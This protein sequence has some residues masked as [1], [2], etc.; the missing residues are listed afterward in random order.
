MYQECNF[1]NLVLKNFKF[2]KLN[3]F[4]S[5]KNFM[6][7]DLNFIF[8]KDLKIILCLFKKKN[9]KIKS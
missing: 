2:L 9:L 7:F 8:Y 1:M 3:L 4:Y 5:S 6:K